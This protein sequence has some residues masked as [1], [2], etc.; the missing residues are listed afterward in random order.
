MADLMEDATD[1]S[2]QGA[3]AAHAVLMCEMERG[4]VRWENGDRIDRIRTARMSRKIGKIGAGRI[5]K[6]PGSAKIS[7]IMLA[8]IQKTM[9]QMAGCKNIYAL[10]V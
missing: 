4:T 2:W 5:T 9:N 7:R 8:V 10:F 3:K 6:N 1:F